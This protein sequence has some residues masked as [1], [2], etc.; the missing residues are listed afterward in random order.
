MK[1][2]FETCYFDAAR[3]DVLRYA[4]S[5]RNV[6]KDPLRMRLVSEA[7]LS[8]FKKDFHSLLIFWSFNK[9]IVRVFS[10]IATSLYH[11]NTQGEEFPLTEGAKNSFI[12]LNDTI[13][14][15]PM[16]AFSN[17]KRRFFIHA[18]AVGGIMSDKQNSADKLRL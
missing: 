6:E 14:K 12:M 1:V 15:P 13:N 2:K 4:I 17:Q 8:Q 10:H 7:R 16:L 9:Q 11:M 18:G 5:K 3:V